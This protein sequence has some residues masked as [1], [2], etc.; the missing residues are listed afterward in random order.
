MQV[1]LQRGSLFSIASHRRWVTNWVGKATQDAK[2]TAN[3]LMYKQK[4]LQAER[5]DI[6]L[7]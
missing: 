4:I 2:E 5:Y 6:V 1:V 3:L 7:L